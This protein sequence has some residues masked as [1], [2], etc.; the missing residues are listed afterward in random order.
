MMR[1]FQQC[2]QV[3]QRQSRIPWFTEPQAEERREC[4]P[5]SAR[6]G[7]VGR[8]FADQGDCGDA[9]IHVE[10]D[11]DDDDGESCCPRRAFDRVE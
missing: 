4:G 11:A 5:A 9:D 6:A 7:L 3:G 10:D 8:R 2:A 1:L